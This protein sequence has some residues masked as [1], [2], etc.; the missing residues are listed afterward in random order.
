MPSDREIRSGHTGV[1]AADGPSVA[2]PAVTLQNLARGSGSDR[3]CGRPPVDL[4]ASG[5]LKLVAEFECVVDF[6]HA[7]GSY[8]FSL[9]GSSDAYLFLNI[10]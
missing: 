7:A 5:S 1:T 6:S 10:S 3:W 9:S 4:Q 2:M 8:V